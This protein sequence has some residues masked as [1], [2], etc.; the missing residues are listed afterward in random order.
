MLR[1]V[2]HSLP[3]SIPLLVM[4]TVPYVSIVINWWFSDP[5]GSY[6]YMPRAQESTLTV[7]RV[8]LQVIRASPGIL[9]CGLQIAKGWKHCLKQQCIAPASM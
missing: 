1:E 5:R 2:S 9:A 6:D 3:T 7:R 8:L 4:S